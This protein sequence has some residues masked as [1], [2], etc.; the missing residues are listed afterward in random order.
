[1]LASFTQTILI[2]RFGPH[3]STEV[4]MEV[5]KSEGKERQCPT[6]DVVHEHVRRLTQGPSV[7]LDLS[8]DLKT[9]A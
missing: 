8:V 9:G 2:T 5:F 6:R 1:M 3:R 7:M 4:A